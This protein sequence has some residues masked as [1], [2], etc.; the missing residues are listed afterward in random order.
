MRY[1][2]AL[3]VPPLAMFTCGKVFQGILCIVLM[4]TLIGWPLAAV[5]AVLVVADY[6]AEKRM[7][8]LAASLR[9]QR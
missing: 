5:W 8:K 4:L 6:K 9:G 2:L 1:L 3:L 7:E